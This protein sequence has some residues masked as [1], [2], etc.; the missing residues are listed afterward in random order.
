MINGALSSSCV[1]LPLEKRYTWSRSLII[2][3]GADMPNRTP[4]EVFPP[5]EFIREELEARGWT[6]RD[7]AGILDMPVGQI[8]ELVTGNQR[9]TLETAHG[10]SSAFGDG[11][12]HYWM[13]LDAAYQ[14][15]HIERDEETIHDQVK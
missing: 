15:A 1:A 2:T 9:I 5:G 7:L 8:D 10:L 14:A 6:E 3:K 4:A 13:N 11:D 12:P